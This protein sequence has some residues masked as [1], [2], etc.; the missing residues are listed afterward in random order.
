MKIFSELDIDNINKKRQSNERLE[1][2]LKNKRDEWNEKVDEVFSTIRSNNM[3]SSEFKRVIDAQADA[4]SYIQAANDE[5][6]FF[7]NKLSRSQTKAKMAK[8]R[9]IYILFNWIPI[10]R[11]NNR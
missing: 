9:K 2:F 11:K 7:M 4:L 3:N 1:D 10:E 5:T 8:T 6:S